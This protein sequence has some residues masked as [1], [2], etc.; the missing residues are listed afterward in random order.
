MDAEQRVILLRSRIEEER[1]RVLSEPPGGELDYPSVVTTHESL[2]SE[3]HHAET[4][5]R[6]A[7]LA[8]D[9]AVSHASG[10]DLYL[11]VFVQPTLAERAGRG[12]VAQI[13]GLSA[14]F[15][16]LVWAIGKIARAAILDR[17]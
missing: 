13:L 2:V 11:A 17:R 9:M 16:C 4:A 7:Q 8:H 1:Q 3:R 10:S 14:L 6:S 12:R 15:L 5:Y